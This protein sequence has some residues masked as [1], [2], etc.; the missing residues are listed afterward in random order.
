MNVTP[1]VAGT[2]VALKNLRETPSKHSGIEFVLVLSPTHKNFVQLT[3]RFCRSYADKCRN[4]VLRSCLSSADRNWRRRLLGQRRFHAQ[5]RSLR[6]GSSRCL[7]RLIYW[8]ITSIIR[9]LKLA[10]M[11][12]NYFKCTFWIGWWHPLF[13]EFLV[14]RTRARRGDPLD[15]TSTPTWKSWGTRLS[16]FHICNYAFHR[17]TMH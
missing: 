3:V 2:K 10:W 6:S 7:W 8:L 15:V 16:T 9:S 14:L 12:R 13:G 17:R 5:I 4:P 1:G 11:V